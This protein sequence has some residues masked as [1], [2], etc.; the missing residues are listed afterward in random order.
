M[1]EKNC[2]YCRKEFKAKQ[3]EINRGNGKF[4]SIKCS[5]KHYGNI[6]SEESKKSHLNFT[7]P[8][9]DKLFKRSKRDSERSKHKINFCSRVCKDR[10]QKI[11]GIKEIQPNHY[12][13]GK[14][15]TYRKAALDNYNHECVKCGYDKYKEVLEVHHIDMK[16]NNNE[17]RNLEILCPTC[18]KEKHHI[19]FKS[20]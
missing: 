18:H 8:V 20:S 19:W 17:L 2:L 4:C 3:K 1:I 11:G 15:I 14:Y 6:R 7:C 12:K 9:C 16:R 5:C 13:D 10:G